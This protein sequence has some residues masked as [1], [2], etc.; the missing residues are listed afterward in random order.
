MKDNGVI[1]MLPWVHTTVSMKNT[2]ISPVLWF[3]NRE[4]ATK[5]VFTAKSI[6]S[7]HINKTIM[8]R[9]IITPKAPITKSKDD[10]M[11]KKSIFTVADD[12]ILIYCWFIAFS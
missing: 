8:F 11:T 4:N 5:F 1:C 6:S 9:R 3:K 10:K 2:N 7:M 12:P